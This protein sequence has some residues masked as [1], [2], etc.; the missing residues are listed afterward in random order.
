MYTWKWNRYICFLLMILYIFRRGTS[1]VMTSPYPACIA[2]WRRSL[3]MNENTPRSSWSIRTCEEGGLC[4]KTSRYRPTSCDQCVGTDDILICLTFRD[5]VH[6]FVGQSSQSFSSTV[7]FQLCQP[8][9]HILISEDVVE[10]SPPCRPLRL[11]SGTTRPIIFLER[12]SSS[13][14][15]MCPYQ[16]ILL[17]LRNVDI[18]LT[19]ASYLWPGFWHCSFSSYPLFIIASTFPL[20]AICSR[21]DRIISVISQSW[22]HQIGEYLSLK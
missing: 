7:C 3:R 20:N 17:C 4:C 5:Y 13:L 2:T 10:P 14:L 1:T 15:L 8:S 6:I 11:V 9:F 22:I 21:T 18:L 19:L 16:S 12:L